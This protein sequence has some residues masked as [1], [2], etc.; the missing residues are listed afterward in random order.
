MDS[1]WGSFSRDYPAIRR[2]I[3]MHYDMAEHS[4]FDGAKPLTVFTQ[5]SLPQVRTHA[6]TN[7]RCFR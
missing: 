5:K 7:L 3:D 4:D 6:S 1:K 2:W